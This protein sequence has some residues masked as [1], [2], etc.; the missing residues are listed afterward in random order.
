MDIPIT[1]SEKW[2]K[3]Q[4]DL[5]EISHF[6][7]QDDYQYLAIEKHTKAGNY[8]FVPY[9]PV[10]TTEKG[11]KT[12]LESL[13]SLAKTIN[14]IF[15]RIEPR[16]PS[17]AEYLPIRAKKVKDIEPAET[18][19]LDLPKISTDDPL[20]DPAVKALLPSRLL[21]YYKNREKQ[22]IT[23]ETSHNPDDIKHLLKLQKALATKKGITTFTENYLKNELKQ[24]FATLYLLKQDKKILAAGLVFDDDATKIRYNLQ[25]AQSEE[26]RPL[27][28]TGILTIQLIKDAITKN[29]DIFDFWG[30]AP[31]GA[32]HTHPWYGFTAFKKTFSGREQKY[33]GTYDLILNSTK[34]KLFNLFKKLNKLIR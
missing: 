29:Y 13:K 15:I 22:G 3:L 30:I 26:G 5:G 7:K 27:H 25:G 4:D 8:L 23:I 34:Y 21:R 2:Q 17:Q 6:E 18:W 31:E 1:Q 32:D 12:A 24:P 20:T 28:A 11:F 19:V 33:A 14:A 16:T 9:G 10:A